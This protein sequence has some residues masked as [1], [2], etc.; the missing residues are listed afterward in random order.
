MMVFS[1]II[2][3]ICLIAFVFSVMDAY[4]FLGF[5]I[6]NEILQTAAYVLSLIG[7]VLFFIEDITNTVLYF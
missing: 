3:I 2:Q 1:T 4:N 7:G 6:K 5:R